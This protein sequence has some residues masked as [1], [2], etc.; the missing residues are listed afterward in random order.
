MDAHPGDGRLQPV[1]QGDHLPDLRVDL[2]DPLPQHPDGRADGAV[3]VV[4]AGVEELLDLL[5]AQPQPLADLDEG[6]PFPGRGGVAAVVA[7]GALGG[8]QQP[9]RS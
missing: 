3:V 5:Q 1:A 2:V 7:G 9:L 4:L 8:G 6:E